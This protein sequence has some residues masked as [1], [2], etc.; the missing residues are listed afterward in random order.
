MGQGDVRC[1]SGHQYSWAHME[2]IRT[3][4]D[5]LGGQPRHCHCSQLLFRLLRCRHACI[6]TCSS[7]WIPLAC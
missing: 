5:M 4:A 1:G 7:L 3:T 6:T 2:H